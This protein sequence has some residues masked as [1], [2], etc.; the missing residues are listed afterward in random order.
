HAGSVTDRGPWERPPEA[1]EPGSAVASGLSLGALGNGYANPSGQRVEPVWWSDGRNDPWRDPN[2]PTEIVVR[3]D[4]AVARI[5]PLE[6][7]APPAPPGVE[8]IRLV[9]LL[10][11]TALLVGLVSGALG[12]TLGYRFG[13]NQPATQLGGDP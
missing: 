10:L 4:P 9:P 6:P 13:V 2:T 5:P 12:G 7:V 11:V 1:A 8:R 3:P